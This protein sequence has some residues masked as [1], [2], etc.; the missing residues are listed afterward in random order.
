MTAGEHPPPARRC[1]INRFIDKFERILEVVTSV[2]LA[3]LLLTV[4]AQVISRYIFNNSLPWTEEVARYVMIW[5]V[6]LGANLAFL[7][8]YLIS[9]NIIVERLPEK[10]QMIIALIRKL[11]ALFF[12]GILTYFGVH[13][14][15]IGSGMQSPA[16]GIQ[17]T[18]IFLAIPVGAAILFFLFLVRRV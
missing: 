5:G 16:T 10:A 17:Y 15:V 14:C 3:V 18:Y 8:G 9:I 4:W 7:K 1:A 2:I 6:L 12:T 11:L 13:L